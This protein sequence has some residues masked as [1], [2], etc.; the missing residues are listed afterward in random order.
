MSAPLAEIRPT[1]ISKANT[2]VQLSL[3]GTALVVPIFQM[4]ENPLF[5]G[6]W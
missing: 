2:L 3:I 5:H 1:L 4:Q 6:L